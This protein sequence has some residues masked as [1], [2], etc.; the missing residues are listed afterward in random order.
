MDELVRGAFDQLLP[1][2]T[3]YDAKADSFL[4]TS[5]LRDGL[6]FD[7]IASRGINSAEI[8][9]NASAKYEARLKTLGVSHDTAATI[10]SGAIK[11][12][13]SSVYLQA[14]FDTVDAL[15]VAYHHTFTTV[16][17]ALNLKSIN[18]KKHVD[19]TPL[20]T[21]AASHVVT[22]IT[23]G[24]RNTIAMT[25]DL[26]PDS[27]RLEAQRAFSRDLN[28]IAGVVQSI[29]G[30]IFSVP[31]ETTKLELEYRAL[32][33]TDTPDM[34]TI[35]HSFDTI[36]R[37]VCLDLANLHK[38]NDGKGCP[39]SYT[40]LP[41]DRLNKLL[42]GVGTIKVASIALPL[43]YFSE[44]GAVHL[45]RLQELYSFFNAEATS[46]RHVSTIVGQETGKFGF[47]SKAIS[48]G[49]IYVGHRVSPQER[50]KTPPNDPGCHALLFNAAAVRQEKWA[51]HCQ[52]LMLLL[53]RAD[54]DKPVYVV[55]C[56]ASSCC[57][58]LDDARLTTYQSGRELIGELV[59]QPQAA[60][61]KGFDEG[62]R[63]SFYAQGIEQSHVPPVNSLNWQFPDTDDNDD[64][65]D[66]E[67]SEEPDPLPEY[68]L[69]R[70]SPD[71]SKTTD[72]PETEE[73]D[74]PLDR[75]FV[76]IPCPGMRCDHNTPREWICFHCSEPLEFC[77][78][79]DHIYCVCGQHLYYDFKCNGES[80]GPGF[81]RY[82]AH[83]LLDMLRSLKSN[84]VN[85]LILGE[86]GVGKSTFING[87]VNYLK[88]NTLDEA[89]AAGRLTSVIPCSFSTQIINKDDPTKK[90]KNASSEQVT[91]RGRMKETVP[92]DSQR[93]NK[94]TYTRGSQYDKKN[95]ADMM[96]TLSDYYVLHGIL[97]LFKSNSP[98]LNVLF[99]FCIKELLTHLHRSAVSNLVFGFTNTRI[100][101]YASGDVYAPLKK[102][103]EEHPDPGLALKRSNIYCFDSESFRY[104][105]AHFERVPLPNVDDMRK[106]W[107]HSKE[108]SQRLVDHFRSTTP[109]NVNSTLS[110]NGA[111]QQ[112]VQ[113]MRSMSE[114]SHHI[115]TSLSMLKR[116][117]QDLR[118]MRLKGDELLAKLHPEIV[119]PRMKKLAKPRTVCTHPE[120]C[121]S[122]KVGKGGKEEIKVHRKICHADCKLT[123]VTQEMLA[124]PAI[125]KC[126]AFDRGKRDKCNAP[127]CRHP[128]QL[129]MHILYKVETVLETVKDEEIE[130]M[131][132]RNEGE[133][134]V[135]QQAFTNA[136]KLVDEYQDELRKMQEARAW[137]GVFLTKNAMAP[138]NDTT[139]EYLD[140]LIQDELT[141]IEA[142]KELGLPFDKNKEIL[143]TLRK[144]RQA[145]LDLVEAFKQSTHKV[146][147]RQQL[148]EKG[149]QD[150][151][152]SLYNLKHF[153]KDLKSLESII[154]SSHK[155][156]CRERPFRASR[157]GRRQAS[158]G[159]FEKRLG[160]EGAVV[161]HGD[162]HESRRK[163]GGQSGLGGWLPS[164]TRR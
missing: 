91:T 15:H 33:Y 152:K 83:T 87:F 137:F 145:H 79:D 114:I 113:L 36:H 77:M 139:V 27:E 60:P 123:N 155:A 72:R 162:K 18:V 49:A 160:G 107:A 126:R 89:I 151:V 84:S 61:T 71:R 99:K 11:P 131:I 121:K 40:L 25:H 138:I 117:R 13:G 28:R 4:A 159:P 46:P 109:H 81:D 95:M 148:T 136:S 161:V 85:I 74:E 29:K 142:G 98:R 1:I 101:N 132:C 17:E 68:C 9:R 64:D 147:D 111:R 54:Q 102:L 7:A 108:E 38:V 106:S 52:S 70:Y 59:G 16:Q 156:T 43:E 150:L 105:T 134:A 158:R 82:P 97:I 133:V 53:W 164:L 66:S 116:N 73:G 115:S 122:R 157:P 41:V 135:R 63:S 75:R 39:L 26:G 57:P 146:Q 21:L 50:I 20:R 163:R 128:W 30:D 103:L 140:M 47:L 96:K 130:R 143:E 94:Q 34:H 31:P 2:G 8:T 35:Q 127:G 80:H 90:S 119:Q 14:S 32:L 6:P 23:W 42:P 129:H 124:D 110:M 45:Q 104:L 48:A 100:S 12:R 44:A 22:G 19:L 120:C 56:D 141:K 67:D 88:Y 3:L 55:D 62:T 37:S 93:P 78:T 154:T 86:T 144:D 112:V 5:F 58:E 10:L 92:K 149:I 24:T 51:G 125:M 76:K 65:E 153:G 118:D 69:A